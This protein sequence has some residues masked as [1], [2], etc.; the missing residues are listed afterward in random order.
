MDKITPERRSANMSRIRARDTKPEMVV[1]QTCHRLGYRFRL[2]RRDLPGAPDLVFA[3]RRAAVFVH[4]CFWHQ[5]AC[6]SGVR[7]PKSNTAYWDA[8]LDRNRQ[9]DETAAR[10]LEELGWRV[11]VVW[12]CELRDR[13]L[14]EAR[15][16]G[17]LGPPGGS[18]VG[19]ALEN[20][21]PVSS[22]KA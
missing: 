5:H 1:R 8:K 19:K 16:A 21:I 10:R 7:R 13:A 14:L 9:R 15:L 12:E 22:G 17:F 6:P 18:C 20:G 11:L 4:G 3:G 2:H